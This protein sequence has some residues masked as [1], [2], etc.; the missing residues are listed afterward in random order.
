[1][2]ANRSP[3]RVIELRDA[4]AGLDAV[5]VVDHELFPV[6]AGGTRMVPDVD[7]GEVA[8]LARAMTWKF[9]SCRLRYAGAK[10]GVRFGDGDRAAVLG[11]YLRALEPLKESFLTG[12]DMG[13]Y[14]ADF[15][16]DPAAELPLWAQS[17][18]GM[19]MDDLATGH[20]VMAAAEAALAQLGRRLEG[21][22]VAIE[23]FGKVGAG[24]ARACAQGGAKVVALSTVE[25]CIAN[26]GGLDVEA[27]LEL[28]FRHGDGLVRHAAVPVRPREDLFTAVCDVVVPGARPDSV[29]LEVV[30]GLRCAVVAPGANVPYAQG[31]VEAL[32]ARG[33]VA[34]PDF[35]ANSGGVHL[36]E[37]LQ[38]G[39]DPPTALAR[40]EAIVTEM[41]VRV[42]DAARA[43][44]VTP[45][46]AALEDG[47]RWL[48][49]SVPSG[50]DLVEELFPPS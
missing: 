23:G 38:P 17:Y 26:R 16:E 11:A 13:T 7:V 8:R 21:A 24:A 48:L 5:V 2:A 43:T 9:A 30:E 42:L 22:T 31:A 14:P 45:M 25:G 33:I 12:P 15:V 18:Q 27:L 6:S 19:G 50:A 39:D 47:R 41:T 40:I 10:A 1:M 29:T 44:G 37:S 32:H 49:E 36:Y 46:A 35:V 20:G 28:R 4:E 34:L 3:A